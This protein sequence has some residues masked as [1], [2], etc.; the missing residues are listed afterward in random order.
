MRNLLISCADRDRWGQFPFSGHS[1]TSTT[2]GQTSAALDEQKSSRL[3]CV[4]RCE[5][6]GTF[7]SAICC[8]RLFSLSREDRRTHAQLRRGIK[9]YVRGKSF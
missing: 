8:R 5:L 6:Q 4:V 1:L 2:M 9:C 7:S 3:R